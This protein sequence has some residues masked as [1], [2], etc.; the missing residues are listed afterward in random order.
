LLFKQGFSKF[1][2]LYVSKL[3]NLDKTYPMRNTFRNSDIRKSSVCRLIKIIPFLVVLF[4]T[5]LIRVQAQTVTDID[6]N[7]YN[8]VTI[9]TQVWMKENLKTTKYNDGTAIPNITDNTAWAALRTGAYSDNNN[10]PAN[11]TIYGRLYNWYAVDNDA[12]TKVESN[13][14]KNV[15]PTGWHVPADTEWTTLTTYLGGE[16]V[17]GGK[18]KE[19]GTTHWASPN[20]VA[21]NETGFTALPGGYRVNGTYLLNYSFGIWWSSTAYIIPTCAWPR[22]MIYNTASV[23]RNYGANQDGFSVRCLR[24]QLA[25]DITDPSTSVI[26]IYP[27]PAS[28]ILNIDYKGEIFETVTVLN[29]QGAPLIKVKSITP[30]QQLDFS[31]YI[32]G[33]YF[34]EFKKVTGEV[35]RF[36]VVKR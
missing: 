7:V 31:K 15:C 28:G 6:G 16:S 34:L 9:G 33:L 25:T 20:T 32:P 36:K 1:I 27:N 12:I 13:G 2:S 14:G 35:R 26:E 17:A 29:S 22:G 11:S 8:T 30:I 23:Y 19:T 21:T 4:I 10:T 5:G 3:V 24:D 18:L